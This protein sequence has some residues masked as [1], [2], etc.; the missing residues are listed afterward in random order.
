MCACFSWSPE[1][2]GDPW[3]PIVMQQLEREQIGGEGLSGNGGADRE[4]VGQWG[5]VFLI[6]NSHVDY[7]I[8]FAN[9]LNTQSCV[10][11]WQ[12]KGC[13]AGTEHMGNSNH[14]FKDDHT[15]YS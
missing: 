7:P 3:F 2:E 10:N 4:I 6:Q 13:V 5:K 14:Q 9:N 15:G 11:S 8:F 12:C 1:P